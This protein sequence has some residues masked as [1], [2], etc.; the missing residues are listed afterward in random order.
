MENLWALKTLNQGVTYQ[1]V[2]EIS[3][4]TIFLYSF[5][6]TPLLDPASSDIKSTFTCFLSYGKFFYIFKACLGWTKKQTGTNLLKIE[7]KKP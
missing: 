7:K 3:R 2:R 6:T 1:L 5:V 4:N